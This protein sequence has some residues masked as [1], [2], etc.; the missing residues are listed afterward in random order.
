MDPR[1][2]TEEEEVEARLVAEDLLP[3]VP[4]AIPGTT[5][6]SSIVNFIPTSF[7]SG[8]GMARL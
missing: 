1:P 3:S 4:T 2:E 8:M 5:S 7:L 6:G